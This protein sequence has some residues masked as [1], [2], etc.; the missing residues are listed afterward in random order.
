[1]RN[2]LILLKRLKRLKSFGRKFLLNL[3][4]YNASSVLVGVGDGPWDAMEEFDDQLPGRRYRVP[5]KK[6][7]S[8]V[9]RG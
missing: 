7:F 1:M 3:I 9:D 6:Y 2:S 4:L 8:D 5:I